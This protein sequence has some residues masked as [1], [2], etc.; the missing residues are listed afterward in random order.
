MRFS[1]L[2]V[3]L[4]M[5]GFVFSQEQDTITPSKE[6]YEY[7]LER[8]GEVTI[9][10]SSGK[11]PDKRVIKKGSLKN[12]RI[13]FHVEE[14]YVHPADARVHK[15]KV[16]KWIMGMALEDT[17]DGLLVTEVKKG[18]AAD[19]AGI[20]VGDIILNLEGESTPDKVSFIQV[21]REY[22]AGEML[23]I[24]L[25]KGLFGKNVDILFE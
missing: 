19:D 16:Q 5:G 3:L 25:K 20:I 7:F 1:V 23:Q 21:W 18:K 13:M 8:D 4:L 14:E 9:I 10:D 11:V 12:E 17:E 15:P 24:R 6:N 2:I 22:R